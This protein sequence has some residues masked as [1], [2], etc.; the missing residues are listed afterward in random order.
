MVAIRTAEAMMG[1]LEIAIVTIF[2]SCS[3]LTALTIIAAGR[4]A[5][6]DPGEPDTRPIVL[7]ETGFSNGGGK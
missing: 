5:H 1:L 6:G 3:T 7:H 4:K 2:T